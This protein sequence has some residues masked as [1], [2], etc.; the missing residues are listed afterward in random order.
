MHRSAAWNMPL[1]IAVAK[2]DQDAGKDHHQLF[3]I[4]DASLAQ[5]EVFACASCKE[6][7]NVY[8]YVREFD[9]TLIYIYIY[10]LVYY[11]IHV[12]LC[13]CN[14]YTHDI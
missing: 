12:E 7:Q 4:V 3:I 10:T 5:N 2:T 13:M 6:T 1:R 8:G 9:W 14:L 11:I